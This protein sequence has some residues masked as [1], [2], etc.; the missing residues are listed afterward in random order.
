MCFPLKSR[1]LAVLIALLGL[2]LASNR[3]PAI[4]AQSGSNAIASSIP[5][6]DRVQ[7]PGWWPTK[8]DPP[9]DAYSGPDSCARCHASITPS[10]RNMAM[11]HASEPVGESEALRKHRDLTFQLDPYK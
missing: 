2:A 5:T 9:R 4:T 7:R 6:P 3:F 10:Y 1:K 8:G 11:A